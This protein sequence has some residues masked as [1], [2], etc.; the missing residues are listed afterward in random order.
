MDQWHQKV[1]TQFYVYHAGEQIGPFSIDEIAAK[2]HAKELEMSD[3]L[4]DDSIRDWTILVAFQAL[5]EAMAKLK[6]NAPAPTPIVATAPIKPETSADEW[7]ALKGELRFGPFA[8]TEIVRLLQDKS[9][10]ES[11][12]VWHVGMSEWQK[13]ADLPEFTADAIKKLRETGLPTLNEVFFR[14]R[15]T[16]VQHDCSI[17]MHNNQKVFRGKG[18]EISAGGAGIVLDVRES[19]NLDVGHQVFLHFKPASDLPPFNAVCE[20]VSRRPVNTADPVAPMHYGVKFLKIEAKL[21]QAI[22]QL[23]GRNRPGHA[24]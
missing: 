3:Y 19:K 17:L 12:F 7:F 4:Y 14:R 24:A 20:V 23:A 16:R 10:Y 8:Y 21:S 11:D 22:E 1:Q 9:M 2:V 6:P 5:S 18:L 15:H 13:I